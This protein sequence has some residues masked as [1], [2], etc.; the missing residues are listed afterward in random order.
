[1]PAKA[2]LVAKIGTVL[3]A[4]GANYA[5]AGT[6]DKHYSVWIFSLAFDEARKGRGARLDGLRAGSEAVF[7]GN[8][9]DLQA[10]PTYAFATVAGA[11]RNW[12]IHVDV[13]I[14]GAS[15]ATH[16][17]DVSVLPDR[18][19][20]AAR[21][22]GR[23]PKLSGAG[24]GVEAKCF[25]SRLTPNEGRVALGFQ[26]EVQSVFWLVASTGNDAVERMLDAPGRK[27]RFFGDM[28]PGA[29]AETELRRALVAQ[30]DR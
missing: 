2:D 9:G 1:M 8:P 21:R 26:A 29:P 23:P 12:E 25:A 19:A 24:F 14:L 10:R 5:P 20:A 18:N 11:Q 27:T 17:V 4:A 28:R 3:R 7:R 15:G 22:G 6:R 13:R 30:L 16:G